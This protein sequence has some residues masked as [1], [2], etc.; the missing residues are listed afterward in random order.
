M[1]IR[2]KFNSLRARLTVALLLLVLLPT[3]TIGWVAYNMVFETVRSER[4]KAVGRIADSK[5]DQL[6]MVLTRANIRAEHFLSDLRDQCSGNSA[7]QNHLCAT[8]LIRSYLAAEGALGATL[9][10]KSG[11]SLTIGT[12]ATRNEEPVTFQTG[13][14]A[15]FSGTGPKSNHSY[16]VSV[17]EESTGFQLAI[18][19]PSSILEPV[20]ATPPKELG[21]SG[22]TF[23][24][25]GE[26]YFVTKPRYAS[27]QGHKLPI[28]A[29]PM[30]S[31]LSGQSGEVLDLDYRDAAIIHGFRFIPEF[32]SACIMAH[33]AQDEAFAPLKSLQQ[34]IIIAI[35]L[36]G[37][38]LVMTAVYLA[39]RIVKPITRLTNVTRAIA[40]GD[41]QAQADAAGR[42]EISELAVSFNFMTDRL[43]AAQQHEAE[44]LSELRVMLNTSNEGFWKVDQS[45]CIVEVNEAYCHIT[46][47]A[48]DEI[49]GAHVSK[50]EAVE[51]TPEAVAAHIRRVVEQ[52]YDR[53]ETRHRHHDGH[54]IDIEVVTS[55][56]EGT[57]SLV[58]FL[59]NVTERKQAETES[60]KT[61]ED[62]RI[63]AIA[64]E[65]QAAIVITDLTPKILRVNRA[66]EEITGYTAAEAIGQ[67]PRILSAPEIRKS[68]AYYEEMWAD[69][70]SKGKWSGEV[71][72]K[73]KNGEIYPKWL[74]ITAVA[75]PDGTITHYVGSF[76]DITE[77]KKV[78]HALCDSRDDLHR[79]LNSMAEGVYGIN[80]DGNCTFVNRSFMQM[81]GYQN[82]NE[83]LGKNM[84]ELIHHSRT[85]G[86]P[87]PVSECKI[88]CAYQTNQITNIDDEVFWSKDGVAIPVE[89][90]S[91][92]I[93]AGDVVTGS[94]VTFVDITERKKAEEDINRLAFYDPLTS[95]PNR[96][97]LQDR[98]QQAMAVSARSGRH[99]ALLFLDLDHFKTI[100]D[101]QGHTMGDLLLI[102]VARRLQ[103]CVREGDS[104][105][106][107][108]GDEFVV[109][110]EELN[111]QPDEAATQAELVAEKIRDELGQPYA[112][113]D[114]E[115]L[116]TPSIGISL[117]LDHQNK[118]EDLFK[119]ADIAM[120]QA[121]TAGRNAIR[122]FDPQMQMTLDIRAAL[123][124]DLRQALARQQ[125]RLYYQVQVDSLRRPLGTEVLL[126]WE[127]P[128][129]GLVSPMQF[130]PLT[131]ETGLIVP[132]GMWVLET[133][134]AQ[135]KAWQ[136]DALTRDLT[137]AVNVSAKQF[138]QADFVT[139]VQRV[140]LESGAKPSHLKLELT[141]STVLEN[142]QDTIAKM[143][144]IKM[145]GV[146]FSM[147]DFGTGY[148]SL[149]Y[150]KR[151]PLDQI[152]IDR[153][154]VLDITSDPNDAAIVQAIIAMTEALGLNVIAEGVETE[155]QRDFLDKH[156]CHAFQGYLFG[157]PVPLEQFEASLIR[158]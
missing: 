64:F 50:F 16:F 139:Q 12:S 61:A 103:S 44:A 52:G 156:G 26:G 23:L 14:L 38:V 83:V 76:F 75:A 148:S 79:L 57:K 1:A 43:Q 88:Y 15:K 142:V 46:G 13:Q 21:L 137:L 5:H 150:L 2:I 108:G 41:Y 133:A 65:T 39:K 32:G 141:E 72:D 10:R 121:K 95:L 144:E 67:N 18:T 4:I 104:V 63:A 127:H 135:L 42:D 87:Y 82:D 69:L 111:S 59:H 85:D 27:T 129:R 115:C 6:V 113:N 155:A 9:R 143:R 47:Y 117:F 58:V 94:I 120:Y 124:A 36:F 53:F 146:N 24:A 152:K 74:T 17:A 22:E 71:L 49:V 102:E 158:H 140:L 55:Y 7:S 128:E 89:Y 149:Q 123:E 56:I 34:K 122:F 73:R 92:P 154:F 91:H 132:I 110:L 114:F 157:K 29:P 145:L 70:L 37:T 109:V 134:C 28:S 78:E 105:A 112:L 125:F 3:I 100:N 54:L 130:I 20:F 97:L 98:L 119:H 68:K 131:E 138:H 45:G 101:T 116:V 106:R 31:C 126:R 40:A 8:G 147:D 90:W 118:M 99:G 25:D 51:Q 93:M 60:A 86:S 151:L 153:S 96:R 35:F 48:R 33:I 81:L 80:T 77:R 19:Y 62:L 30:Q 136:N 11:D 107:L 84:H 66:F